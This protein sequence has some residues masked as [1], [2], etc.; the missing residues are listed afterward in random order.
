[1]GVPVEHL[2]AELVSLRIGTGEVGGNVDFHLFLN[3]DDLGRHFPLGRV[4]RSP[5]MFYRRGGD[6][7]VLFG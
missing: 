6:A 3:F 2:A 7:G 1:M 5:E 4:C